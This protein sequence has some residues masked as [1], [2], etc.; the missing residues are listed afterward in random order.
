MKTL[1]TIFAFF[2]LSMLA[3]AC[4]SDDGNAPNENVCNFEG[5]TV[6]WNNNTVTTYPEADLNAELFPNNDGSG[7]PAIEIWDTTNP[8]NTFI[9]TRALAQGAVD[10]NPEIRIEGTD[11]TGVVTCQRITGLAVGDDIRYDIIINGNVEA[12]FCG[13]IDTV[14]P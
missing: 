14:N 13:D 12:E 4:D 5:V 9:V 3:L 2:L 1:K 8:G 11:Y 10:N 6:E 7:Q